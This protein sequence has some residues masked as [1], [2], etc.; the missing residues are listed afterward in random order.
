MIET[1]NLVLACDDNYAQH[2]A[3]TLMSAYE[4][5]KN[6]SN[7]ESFVLDG[8]I[9]KD[10][11]EKIQRSIEQ[12]GGKVSFIKID[13]DDYKDM[14]TSYQYSQAIYYRLAL[15]NLLNKKKC[16]YVDCDLLFLD[17]IEK[18]W[19]INLNGHP[20]GAIE[21]I[22]LT[23]SKKRFLE[24]QKS[25]GLKAG[26]S[27]FNSGVV[28]MDLEQWREKSYSSLAM[29]LAANNDFTSH[30][31]DVLNKLFMDNWEQIDL[32]WNVIPPITYMYPKIIFNKKER[33]RSIR[34]R[35]N[36][37]ILHYAG[38]YKAWEFK[39]YPEFNA[40]YYELLRKSAFKDVAMP[41]LSKQNVG[42]NFDKEVRR[43]KLADLLTRFLGSN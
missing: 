11:K 18:L 20:V 23:T 6:K 43:L 40:F 30:D 42:R 32:R 17:D 27:Y 29:E 37:G 2:A 41:Q 25:I 39:E 14:Y 36:P 12:Y 10:K 22:G 15:P 19:N 4:K 38:R 34:A 9:S 16:I 26:S 1:I 13:E 31:Q 35:K 5:S 8:G 24:K 28:I 7:I 33:E 3:I 21:D